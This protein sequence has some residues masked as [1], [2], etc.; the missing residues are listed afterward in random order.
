MP[1]GENAVQH[2]T[3][4]P[5]QWQ[6]FFLYKRKISVENDN[7]CEGTGVLEFLFSTDTQDGS[8]K[9]RSFSYRNQPQPDAGRS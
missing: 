1:P 9:K 8:R 6:A 5:M 7:I 4:S 3:K 2:F